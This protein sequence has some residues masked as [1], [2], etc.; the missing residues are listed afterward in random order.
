[1]L[2]EHKQKTPTIWAKNIV[3]L[4][5]QERAVSKIFH[6]KLASFCSLKRIYE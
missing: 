1:M 5:L 2:E 6:Q 4:L 3:A